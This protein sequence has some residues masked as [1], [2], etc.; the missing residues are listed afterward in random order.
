LALAAGRARD[1]MEVAEEHD[2]PIWSAV[3]RVLE[4]AA[5]AGR[6]EAD[7][8]LARIDDGIARYE[9]LRTPPVFWPLILSVRARASALAG[10]PAEGLEPIR[11]ALEQTG[12]RGILY[13]EFALLEGE[14][15]DALG[16]ADGAAS[17]FRRAYDVAGGIGARMT[18]LRAATRL[19][20]LRPEETAT[21]RKVYETFTEGLETPEQADARAALDA[22]ESPA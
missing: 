12:E 9:G 18:Q 15:L 13:P 11:D 14:L 22:I 6:G 7:E 21:L 2:F 5:T 3:S 1:A 10:R 4:G 19:V 17:R 8:G 16:D 20:R